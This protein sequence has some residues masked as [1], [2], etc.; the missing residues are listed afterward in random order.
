MDQKKNN[1]IFITV[2]LILCAIIA[3]IFFYDRNRTQN[4]ISK[5]TDNSNKVVD[6]N[7]NKEPQETDNTE[8]KDNPETVIPNL[9]CVG[10]STTLGKENENNS[11]PAYLNNLAN[12]NIKTIGDE[13][14]TSSALL[15]KLGITPV[16]VDKLTIPASTTPT[17]IVFLNQGGKANNELL[18]SQGSI[19]SVTING[20]AGKIT[21]RYEGNTLLFTRDQPGEQT[22]INSPTLIQVNNNIEPNGILILYTGAYEESIKGSLVKYQ[23]E[24]IQAFNTENYLVVSLTQNDRNETNESLKAAHGEHYLDFKSYL[25]SNGLQDAGITPTAQDLQDIA[26][27][28]IPTSLKANEI[29]GNDKYCQLLSKQILDK[30]TTLKYIN[31]NIIK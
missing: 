6:T 28:K 12:L 4:F 22:I 20:I 27:N 13:K 19:E 10:D 25:L 8:K 30:L 5:F 18:K 17:P 15:V 16:Y 26:E 7:K 21:Y 14:I 9:Y 3:L 1:I 24:I 29:N 23:K 11:Y 2:V 31:K